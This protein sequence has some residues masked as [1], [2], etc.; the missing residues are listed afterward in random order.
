LLLGAAAG[1]AGPLLARYFLFSSLRHIDLSKAVIINQTQPLW[2][3]L[4]AS[5]A[6]GAVPPTSLIPGGVLI[7]AGCMLLAYGRRG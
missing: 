4:I 5:A 3:A 7:V 6:L 1:L 2:V